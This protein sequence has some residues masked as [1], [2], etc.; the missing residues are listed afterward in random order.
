MVTI[1][2]E[3]SQG[4]VIEWNYDTPQQARRLWNAI[5]KTGRAPDTDES[6]FN[7]AYFGPNNKPGMGPDK[8]WVA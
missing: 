8:Y 4:G 6:L 7:A 2:A 3:R 5:T 1:K